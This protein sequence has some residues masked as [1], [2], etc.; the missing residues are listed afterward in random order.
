MTALTDVITNVSAVGTATVSL[1]GQ[2]IELFTAHPVLLLFVGVGFTAIGIR[3]GVR[4]L[5]AA[6][7]MA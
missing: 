2:G 1:I 7:K 5:R 3:Y 6:K 4:M